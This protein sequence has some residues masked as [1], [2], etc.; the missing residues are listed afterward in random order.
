MFWNLVNS[1]LIE[2]TRLYLQSTSQV[3]WTKMETLHQAI[4][5]CL[6]LSHWSMYSVGFSWTN[7]KRDS[8][9]LNMALYQ[10]SHW[11]LNFCLYEEVWIAVGIANFTT[12]AY[13]DF[14]DVFKSVFHS[15]LTTK[16]FK[17]G[18]DDDFVEFLSSYRSNRYHCVRAIMKLTFFQH[19]AYFK[20][21]SSCQYPRS[22]F[23]CLV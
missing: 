5:C 22:L 1:P 21:S 8:I 4:S 20:R 2:N 12:A 6:Y 11:F 14:V 23:L 16:L 10:R 19:Y 3:F 15:G 9:Q 7:W 18:L 17:S 13:F